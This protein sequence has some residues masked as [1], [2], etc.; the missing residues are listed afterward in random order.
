MGSYMEDGSAQMTWSAIAAP[1]TLLLAVENAAEGGVR[2]RL[3]TQ[4]NTVVLN[5]VSGS[6]MLRSPHLTAHSA[7]ICFGLNV[8]SNDHTC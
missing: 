2:M 6:C 7:V 1:D 8:C 3:V 5:A 4:G